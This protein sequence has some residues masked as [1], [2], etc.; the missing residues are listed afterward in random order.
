MENGAAERVTLVANDVVYVPLSGIGRADL[1]VKQHIKD[2]IP[3][4]VFRPPSARD[5]FLR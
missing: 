5:L 3:W 2:L 4:E 1:W